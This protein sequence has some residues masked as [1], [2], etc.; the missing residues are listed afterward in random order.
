MCI[1]EFSPE[2]LLYKANS[3]ITTAFN[4]FVL[5][6]SIHGTVPIYCFV[7]GHELAYYNVRVESI[8]G[9]DCQFIEAKGKKAVIGIHHFLKSQTE[10]IKYKTLYFVDKDYDDN[11]HIDTDIYITPGY[12]VENFYA[13]E[14]CYKKIIQGIFHIEEDNPKYS[15][16]ISL[17]NNE[18]IKFIEAASPLCAWYKCVKNKKH[19]GVELGNTFPD[20]YAKIG[21]ASIDIIDTSLKTIAQDYPDCD[22]ISQE[23]FDA[24]LSNIKLDINNIRG[25]YV[26][27]FIEYLLLFLCKDSTTRKEYTDSKTSFEKNLKT[28]LSRLSTHADTPLCLRTYITDKHN[29]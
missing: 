16:C 1:N 4:R 14:K 8:T 15:K 22:P 17:Y 10:Y 19:Q 29:N 18:K 20:K 26:I 11:S 24:E 25:K 6:T 28:I 13:S 27:Q 23:E 9:K 5:K 12:A 2:A 21:P 3:N 7:E